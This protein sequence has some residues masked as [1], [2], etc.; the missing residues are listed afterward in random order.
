MVHMETPSPKLSPPQPHH[1]GEV[2]PAALPFYIFLLI[3]IF[4][5][6]GAQSQIFYHVFRSDYLCTQRPGSQWTLAGWLKS[7]TYLQCPFNWKAV[8]GAH[9]GKPLRY[10]RSPWGCHSMMQGSLLPS[11]LAHPRD[12]WAVPQKPRSK[13]LKPQLQPFT[14]VQARP[15]ECW[16]AADGSRWPD[17][18]TDLQAWGKAHANVCFL[19]WWYTNITM[20]IF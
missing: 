15:G 1:S 11:L 14:P 12:Y 20:P 10:W 7:S 13:Q 9:H 18:C 3:C 5:Q 16:E 4:S 2:N 8:Y 17:H 6:V 19:S